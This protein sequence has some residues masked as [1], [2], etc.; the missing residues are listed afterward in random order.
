MIYKIDDFTDFLSVYKQKEIL[1]SEDCIN[2]LSLTSLFGKNFDYYLH[3]ITKYV[4]EKIIKENK[5]PEIL[6]YGTG[7]GIWI[8][9]L[10]IQQ[11]ISILSETPEL[12]SFL[13]HILKHPVENDS[14]GQKY[15]LIISANSNLEILPV[16]TKKLNPN[17]KLIFVATEKFIKDRTYEDIRYTVKN[18]FSISEIYELGISCLLFGNRLILPYINLNHFGTYYLVIVDNKFSGDNSLTY[19]FNQYSKVSQEDM[20]LIKDINISTEKVKSFSV[21]YADLGSNWNYGYNLPSNIKARM[22]IARVGGTSLMSLCD[23]I[24]EGAIFYYNSKVIS[25]VYNGL[26]IVDDFKLK[27]IYSKS[28]NSQ[29][30][31]NIKIQNNPLSKKLYGN[32]KNVSASSPKTNDTWKIEQLIIRKDDILLSKKNPFLSYRVNESI[33]DEYVANNEL[34]IIRSQNSEILINFFQSE[35]FIN[36]INCLDVSNDLQEQDLRKLIVPTKFIT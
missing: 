3:N 2:E 14:D 9:K 33:A 1:S 18:Y 10:N 16:I 13:K 30:N 26:K 11:K 4:I 27:N 29:I 35:S 12:S 7:N 34:I 8:E 5:F 6:F 19:F 25:S 24:L 31:E 32:L 28:E 36:Q 20:Q 22:S 23:R 21:N 17:G 15:D